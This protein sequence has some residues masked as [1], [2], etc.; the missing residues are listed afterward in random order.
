MTLLV[1]TPVRIRHLIE[2]DGACPASRVCFCGACGSRTRRPLI[3]SPR[4][5]Q[6]HV[7]QLRILCCGVLESHP[8][9][10]PNMLTA[11]SSDHSGSTLCPPHNARVLSEE[12][13]RKH[14]HARTHSFL[15]H[16]HL[17]TRMDPPIPVPVSHTCSLTPLATPILI[18]LPQQQQ[19]QQRQQQRTIQS[20]HYGHGTY[21]T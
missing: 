1:T 12:R 15:F 4:A 7:E 16:P 17:R 19:K 8:S 13:L 10:G 2:P 11:R 18:L 20:K 3:R 6:R 9:F 5:P 14:L 21:S